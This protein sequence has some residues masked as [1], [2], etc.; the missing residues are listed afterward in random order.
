MIYEGGKRHDEYIARFDLRHIDQPYYLNSE[1]TEV[2]YHTINIDSTIN[3]DTQYKKVFPSHTVSI[4][5]TPK[6]DRVTP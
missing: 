6:L 5:W 2:N 4:G 3:P 1:K